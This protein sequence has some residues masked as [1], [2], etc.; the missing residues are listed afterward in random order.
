[1]P[2]EPP[3][4]EDDSIDSLVR[5]ALE[6][7]AKGDPTAK[8]DLL[9]H[10]RTQ[11]TRM[12]RKLLRGSP[13]YQSIGRWEQTD[14]VVQGL[15]MR[16]SDTI[17]Q[18]KRFESPR[19]FFRLAAK[20]IH[21][22]LKSLRERHIAAKRNI[23]KYQSDVEHLPD[24]GPDDVGGHVV[25]ARAR[26]DGLATLSQYLDDIDTL[27]AEDRE[28]LDLVLIHSLTIEEAA[29]HLKMAP[30]TFKRHYRNARLRLRDHFV[31]DE[32][33]HG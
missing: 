6:R 29:A 24:N 22:E 4:P 28:L 14:D 7:L 9:T 27:S 5:S 21:W 11:F 25:N 26:E 30:A 3:Q 17:D 32:G 2:T 13:A 16:M 10:T 12:A 1:M 18:L 31:D 33:K 20:N 23:G 15:L 8:E 19:D